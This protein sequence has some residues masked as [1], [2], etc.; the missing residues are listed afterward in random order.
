MYFN[1]LKDNSVAIAVHDI[2]HETVGPAPDGDPGEAGQLPVGQGPIQRLGG[3]H[4]KVQDVQVPS[5][6]SPRIS[7][8]QWDQNL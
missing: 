1:C 4:R 8:I 2:E 3:D 5:Q 6:D 7:Q